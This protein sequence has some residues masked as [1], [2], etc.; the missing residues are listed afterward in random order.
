MDK[1]HPLSGV[2]AAQSGS[3]S[4]E[5]N[6][7]RAGQA[8]EE[9]WQSGLAPFTI[10]L[11]PVWLLLL[12]PGAQPGAGHGSLSPPDSA[13]A[14]PG[15]DSLEGA[16]LPSSPRGISALID[17]KPQRQ[18]PKTSARITLIQTLAE[19]ALGETRRLP[20]D[21]GAGTHPI[22]PLDTIPIFLLHNKNTARQ[23]PVN[24]GGKDGAAESQKTDPSLKNS[25]FCLANKHFL[26]APIKQTCLILF[27][28]TAKS[29]FPQNYFKSTT[30][31][32]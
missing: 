11:C 20:Q 25:L 29:S 18:L 21:L 3:G 15:T 1:Q 12:T 13:E 14:F 16:P 8:P 32:K 6:G 31:A 26:F 2:L 30:G 27:C 7:H 9:V 17:C 10:I 23:I 28:F 4:L 5:Q 24:K 22:Y 19:A